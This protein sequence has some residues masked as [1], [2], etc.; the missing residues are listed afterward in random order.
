[1]RIISI[2]DSI[3][4]DIAT[5]THDSISNKFVI[6]S[7]I[8]NEKSNRDFIKE[9]YIMTDVHDT[10]DIVKFIFT[11][12]SKLKKAIYLI[13]VDISLLYNLILIRRIFNKY[14]R[15]LNG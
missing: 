15:Y 5:V 6:L 14:R 9:I 12:K 3:L 1:M 2:I 13:I 7:S 8:D 10:I 11:T 4:I